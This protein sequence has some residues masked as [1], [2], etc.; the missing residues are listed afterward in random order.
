MN[1][2]AV[3]IIVAYV[4]LVTIAI[5]LSVIV[6]SWLRDYVPSDEMPE[7]PEGVSLII[8]D[9]FCF[10]DNGDKF[11]NITLKNKGLFTIK[12]FVLRVH[13]RPDAEIGLYTLDQEGVEIL[14]GN[15]INRQ[16]P[17]SSVQEKELEKISLIEVQPIVEVKREDV[18]CRVSSQKASNCF[19]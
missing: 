8:Q 7:C 13:D 11:L 3:S 15:S 6:Y 17:F 12:G 5:S 9:Y 16:Y 1:K 19:N 10:E 18:Y 14:P 2:K 4:L